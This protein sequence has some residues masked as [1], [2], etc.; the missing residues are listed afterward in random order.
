MAT[1]GDAFV[2]YTLINT[3]G[4]RQVK[5][6]REYIST[7]ELSEVIADLRE[8][9]AAGKM[10]ECDG[11][12]ERLLEDGKIDKAYI[13]SLKEKKRSTRISDINRMLSEMSLRQLDNVRKY[14]SDEYDEPDHEA[15][16]LNAIIELSRKGKQRVTDE[17]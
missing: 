7:E 17:S 8:K 13:D 2:V 16:A 3:E 5:M 9:I 6:M 1:A 11:L 10:E 14:V 12:L 4:K 15:E